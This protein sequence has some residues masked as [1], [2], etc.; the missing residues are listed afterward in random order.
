VVSFL[1]QAA[2]VLEVLIEHDLVRVNAPDMPEYHKRSGIVT[3]VEVDGAG[4]TAVF[5]DLS[6]GGVPRWFRPAQLEL[7]SHRLLTDEP[8]TDEL[9]EADDSNPL[10]Y[11]PPTPTDDPDAY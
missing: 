3:A 2:Q 9:P 7:L 4:E 1:K 10:D 8:P 5:V 11:L 6:N